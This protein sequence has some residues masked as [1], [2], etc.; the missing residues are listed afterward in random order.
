MPKSFL[1]KCRSSL[2]EG[3]PP[4][5]PDTSYFSVQ[6]SPPPGAVATFEFQSTSGSTSAHA[7]QT[8]PP[9]SS[10]CAS[11]SAALPAEGSKK[12][13]PAK[14]E[15]NRKTSKPVA[16]VTG[17]QST[18]KN[19]R[20]ANHTKPLNEA[21]PF[22]CALCGK[23]FAVQRM[24]NRHM[25]CHSAT[26]RYKCEHCPKGFNDTF[27]LKRHVRTHTGIRPYKCEECGKGFTQRCSL[28]SHYK[29]VHGLTL[30]YGYK[31]RREKIYVCEECGHA[32]MSPEEHLEH[33]K[34]VHPENP[35]L[36]KSF[37]RKHLLKKQTDDSKDETASTPGD[38]ETDSD[39]STSD[40]KEEGKRKDNGKQKL[41]AA[42]RI[43]AETA[44]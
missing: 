5:Y 8:V 37:E 25:K 21:R 31:E 11:E 10:S 18:A 41:P 38:A 1:V 30:S 4:V 2:R 6:L 26:K 20:S 36:N 32:T 7:Q 14:T 35:G 29:K 42:K 16:K 22:V 19:E 33:L 12:I 27:D 28:E 17:T 24:L 44:A 15:N 40:K 9:E 13:S 39:D 3:P 43:R 23:D 34:Q